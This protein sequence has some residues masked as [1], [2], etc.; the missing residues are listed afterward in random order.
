MQKTGY[1][2]GRSTAQF[3]SDSEYWVRKRPLNSPVQQRFRKLGT[4]EAAQL[5]SST[6]IQKTGYARGRSTAQLERDSKNSARKRRL[7]SPGQRRFRKRGTQ[8]AAQLHSSTDIQKT[9]HARGR[10]TAQFNRDSE[11]W[12]RKRPL[13]CPVLHRFKKLGTQ[14]QPQL[15]SSKEFRKTGQ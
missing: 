3:F 10:S 1:A 12:V 5:P 15:P 7:N 13:N 2:R 4:Q 8:E 11:N 6:E 9:R 14:D